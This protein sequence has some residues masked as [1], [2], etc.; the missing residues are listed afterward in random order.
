MALITSVT[1][2][3]SLL[4]HFSP[5]ALPSTQE[6]VQMWTREYYIQRGSLHPLQKGCEFNDGPGGIDICRFGAPENPMIFTGKRF[7]SKAQNKQACINMFGEGMDYELQ[8]NGQPRCIDYTY[9][10]SNSYIAFD[11]MVWEDQYKR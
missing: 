4:T 2:M 5:V 9:N 8:P 11:S 7:W 10:L 3:Y 6:V 1:I